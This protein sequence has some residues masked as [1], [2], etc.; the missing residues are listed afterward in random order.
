MRTRD[1]I[2]SSRDV[3]PL[4]PAEDAVIIYS[5]SLS[6]EETLVKALKYIEG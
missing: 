5:T 2:D 1:R 6:I 4:Q 3:A